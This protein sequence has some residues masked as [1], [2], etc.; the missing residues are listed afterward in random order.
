MA[1][2]QYNKINPFSLEDAQSDNELDLEDDEF[3]DEFDTAGVSTRTRQ[4]GSSKNSHDGSGLRKRWYCL[5]AVICF[6]AIAA[7]VS[8]RW[9]Q[10]DT[11]SASSGNT[12]MNNNTTNPY[13][14]QSLAASKAR[15]IQTFRNG[16]GLMLNVNIAHQGGTAFC[17]GTCC[18]SMIG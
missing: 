13:N 11:Q 18:T 6:A 7:Y 2:S 12:I 3:E 10:Q 4:H 14:D 5:V 9:K 16:Q 1:T 8:D 15:Q 17:A